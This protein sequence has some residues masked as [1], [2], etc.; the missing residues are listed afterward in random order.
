ML[1]TSFVITV[2]AG[3]AAG[4]RKQPV[5]QPEQ[6]D[7]GDVISVHRSDRDGVCLRNISVRCP[8]GLSCNP[9]EPLRVD[10]P[11]DLRDASADPPAVTRRPPGKEDW[12]RVTPQLWFVSEKE[13]CSYIP[14]Y[15]CAPPKTNSAECTTYP[16]RVKVRCNLGPD[17][18][19]RG[20]E[21]FIY[22]DG[23]GQ[24]HKVPAT[25]CLP[26]PSGLC[27]VPDGDIVPCP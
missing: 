2:S 17:A 26:S 11:P 16:E 24:C 3:G 22:K 5:D 19:E 15:F 10:C 27:Q 20:F 13:G 12:L 25:K 21:E 23:I 7:R 18:G 9:P 14:E 6:E 1:A 8:K 4:C